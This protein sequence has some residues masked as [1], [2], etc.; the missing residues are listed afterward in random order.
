MSWVSGIVAWLVGG[1]KRPAVVGPAKVEAAA[2]PQSRPQPRRASPASSPCMLW[3]VTNSDH[4][5]KLWCGPTVVSALIGID[6]AVAR[7]II[8]SSRGGRAVMGTTARELDLAFRAHGHRLDLVADLTGDPPTLATWLGR[9][10]NPDDALVV[11]ITGHWVAVRGNWFADT[12]TKGQP[13][14]SR[15]APHKRKR[16]R[17]VYRVSRL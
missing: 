15:H 8:K 9:S 12:A 1:F 3:P 14:R 7:D 13:V 6:A 16:V 2:P 10:R 17:A 11:H 5:R 4:R